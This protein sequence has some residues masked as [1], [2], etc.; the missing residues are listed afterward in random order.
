MENMRRVIIITVVAWE[1]TQ[2]E[3]N[4]KGITRDGTT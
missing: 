4:G 3:I 1:S 2:N